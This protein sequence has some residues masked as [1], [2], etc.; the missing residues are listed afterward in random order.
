MKTKE[1]QLPMESTTLTIQVGLYA[2]KQD[3]I[4]A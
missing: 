1:R 2:K 3:P 4:G